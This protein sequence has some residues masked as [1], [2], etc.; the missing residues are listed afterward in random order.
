MAAR[1]TAPAGG[2]PGPGGG[3]RTPRTGMATMAPRPGGPSPPSPGGSHR[4]DPLPS[5]PCFELI[6]F[7]A[8]YFLLLSV[9]RRLAS[10]LGCVLLH[11]LLS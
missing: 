7:A 1:G 5:P 2:A 9:W 10:P 6:P 11:R 3:P 8:L 4:K